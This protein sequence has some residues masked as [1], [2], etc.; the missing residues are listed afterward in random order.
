MFPNSLSFW[1][2][3]GKQFDDYRNT[4][5]VYARIPTETSCTTCAWDPVAQAGTRLDCP[6]CNGLGKV[7][8][9]TRYA[10]NCRLMW[11]NTVKYAYPFPTTGTELGDCIIAVP[12][13]FVDIVD[14]VMS[15]E[16]A[17]IQANDKKV[18]PTSKQEQRIP[19]IV[20]EFEYVCH[21]FSPEST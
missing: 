4:E 15:K 12:Q 17:Y 6:T 16:R 3:Q 18:R 13:E 21:L 10:L 19:G 20:T 11:T 9:W 2:D 1:N 8:T 14:L 7:I 5:T